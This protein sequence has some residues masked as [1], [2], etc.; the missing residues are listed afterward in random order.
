MSDFD[1]AIKKENKK[2]TEDIQR[3]KDEYSTDNKKTYFEQKRIENIKNLNIFLFILYYIVIFITC[4]FVF[5]SDSLNNLT[6][7]IIIL[8]LL[9][10]PFVAS[11]IEYFIFDLFYYVYVTIFGMPYERE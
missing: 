2:I 11:T 9:I 1:Q 7:G 10:F 3:L 6:K 4:I 5:N 8:L